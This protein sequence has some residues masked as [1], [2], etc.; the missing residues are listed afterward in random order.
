MTLGKLLGLAVDRR[1]IASHLVEGRQPFSSAPV[2]FDHE[3]RA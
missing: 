1:H 2:A 3:E